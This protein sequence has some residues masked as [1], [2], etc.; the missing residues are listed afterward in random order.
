MFEKNVKKVLSRLEHGIPL[1]RG[2]LFF[3][4]L[5]QYTYMYQFYSLS[6]L[7]RILSTHISFRFSIFSSPP[8]FFYYNI[9]AFYLQT[10]ANPDP[11]YHIDGRV[12]RSILTDISTTK[13]H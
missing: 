8:L 11:G 6:F 4:Q 10:N 1:V 13:W 9:L 3:M 2:K 5:I 7:L 12:I